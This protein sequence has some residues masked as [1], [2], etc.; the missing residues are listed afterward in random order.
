MCDCGEFEAWQPGTRVIIDQIGIEGS[1]G[2]IVD[3]DEEGTLEGEYL[4]Y[5]VIV[6]EDPDGTER[7]IALLLSVPETDLIESPYQ[8]EDFLEEI[9]G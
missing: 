9:N 6:E 7:R 5:D 4:H 2:F 8:K 3:I 1:I